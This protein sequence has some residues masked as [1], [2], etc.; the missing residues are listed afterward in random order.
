MDNEQDADAEK[1]LVARLRD[2]D[3]SAI[4]LFIDTF[5]R[6]LISWLS[7]KYSSSLSIDDIDEIFNDVVLRVWE[8]FG[9]FDSNK[10]LAPWV[11]TIANRCALTRLRRKHPSNATDVSLSVNE[12][13][14]PISAEPYSG[15]DIDAEESELVQRLEEAIKSLSPR[16]R[17]V[18]ETDIECSLETDDKELA[19]KLGTTKGSI[20]ATRCVAKQKLQAMLSSVV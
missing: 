12:I 13:R 17:A 7:R 15:D 4:C 18:I 14:C 20:Q 11:F 2:R 9:Q 6:R 3:A 5:G 8:K 16:Q 1:C 19:I 10:K